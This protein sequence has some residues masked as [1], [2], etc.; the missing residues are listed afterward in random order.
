MLARYRTAEDMDGL[1][2]EAFVA[3]GLRSRPNQIFLREPARR[4]IW[5]GSEGQNFS[6]ADID[7][8]SRRIAS[9]L[10]L[11]RLPE[12]SQAL[13]F[14]PAGSEQLIAM[15]GALRAGLKPFL[16]PLSANSARLQAW[17]DAA[18][19]SVAIGTS[20][21][22]DVEPALMLRDAAARSFNARLVCAFGPG[23][24]DGVVPLD[25]IIVS[26]ATLP[27]APV[28]TSPHDALT[29]SAETSHGVRQVMRE[30]EIVAATVDIARVAKLSDDHRL[31]SMM[32]SPS[33]C[34]LAAGPYLAML[35]GAEYLPLGLFSLSALWAGLSDGKTTTLVA[36]AEVESPLR[37]SGIIGHESVS[38]VILI[39][40]SRPERQ[41]AIR[42]ELGR[43]LDL[44]SD[45][46]NAVTLLARV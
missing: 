45:D 33:L 24:P 35:T 18:G 40:P 13:L 17:L 4:Q 1:G 39:H 29:V 22:G 20:R 9:L 15:L 7:Q 44:F 32:M 23:A 14:M 28:I 41:A 31:L 26:T 3:V 21:C 27:P 10:S 37:A 5:A 19:P 30:T 25:S 46:A 8:R 43:I 2:L 34:A 11:S 38:A 42:G 36:P 16:M 6:F 12:R